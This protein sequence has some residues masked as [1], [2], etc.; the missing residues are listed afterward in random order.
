MAEQDVVGGSTTFT[1]GSAT[2]TLVGLPIAVS[3]GSGAAVTGSSSPGSTNKVTTS[4]VSGATSASG[5]GTSPTTT[6][7]AMA[8]K[9]GVSSIFA[10]P[11]LLMFASVW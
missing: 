2:G 7:G 5:S 9:I 3:T 11:A 10:V 6:S 8:M 1:S 4:H